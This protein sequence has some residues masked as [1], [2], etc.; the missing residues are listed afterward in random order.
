MCGE[1]AMKKAEV[2]TPKYG[3]YP[4]YFHLIFIPD[5]ASKTL[6]EMDMYEYAKYDYMRKSILQLIKDLASVSS[7]QRQ[8]TLFDYV[9]YK[10]D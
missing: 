9:Q 7:F 6:A 10:E 5:G 3:T 1:I 4:Y 2:I 8:Y